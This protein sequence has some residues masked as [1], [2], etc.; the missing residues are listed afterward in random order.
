M[1]FVALAVLAFAPALLPAAAPVPK[2]GP[3]RVIVVASHKDFTLW[4]IYVVHPDTG[5]SK[6]LTDIKS[7]AYGKDK[8]Q[9]STNANTD[10]YVLP[11][12]SP[13]GTRIA[14]GVQVENAVQIGVVSAAGG[15]T[16]VITSGEHPHTYARWSPD[17]KS[18]G[19]LRTQKAKRPELVVSDPDGRDAK[20]VLPDIGYALEWR[21]R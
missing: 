20:V 6:R 18:L 19:Y 8:K 10:G 3:P 1:R 11:S 4:G 9:L 2:S 5:E 14:Y 17:G 21:P 13:D 7:T 15:E 12:W 16:R